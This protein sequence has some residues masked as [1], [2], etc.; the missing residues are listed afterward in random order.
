MNCGGLDTAFGGGTGIL[1]LGWTNWTA[2]TGM[3]VQSNG[4]IDLA[5]QTTAGGMS[6]AQLNSSGGVVSS[7]GSRG[8][9]K[10]PKG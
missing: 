6:V 2:I 5:V 10:M 9:A 1:M 3:V 7:F 4:N 8:A